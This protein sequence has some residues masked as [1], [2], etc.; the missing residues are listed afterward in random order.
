MLIAHPPQLPFRANYRKANC[1][2][3][4]FF[5]PAYSRAPECGGGTLKT[6]PPACEVNIKFTFIK[7]FFGGLTLKNVTESSK[8]PDYLNTPHPSRCP[9][10]SPQDSLIFLH[11]TRSI[12]HISGLFFCLNSALFPTLMLDILDPSSSLS[13]SAENERTKGKEEKWSHPCPYC[14]AAAMK[15]QL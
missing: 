6:K 15:K 2:I 14:R 9:S 4:I 1:E 8:K 5:F 7:Q 12:C 13:V 3:S 10:S 11:D